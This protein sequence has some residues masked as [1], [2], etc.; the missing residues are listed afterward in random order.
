MDYLYLLIACIFFSLQFIFTKF[1]E[2]RTVGGLSV[3]LYNGIISASVASLFLIVKS[4][5]PAEMN[6]GAFLVALLYSLSGIVCGVSSFM[7]MTYG[8]VSA[9]TTFCLAG[10]MV[11]PYFYGIYLGENP[12]VFKWIG[13]IVLM[14]SLIPTLLKKEETTGRNNRIL[15]IIA[16]SLVFLTN[17]LVSVFS[18]MH[19]I[20]PFAVSEDSFIMTASFIRLALSLLIMVILAVVSTVKGEKSAFKKAFWEIGKNKMRVKLFILL[21]IFA[22]SY[23]VCNTLGNIFSLKCMVTMDASIQFPILSAVVIVLGAVF[24][25]IFFK[26]KITKDMALSLILSVIGIGLFMIP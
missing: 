14:I 22:G 1:F 6:L 12:G 5:L 11:V 2:K 23:A 4:G 10:G 19:Q 17:G 9:V 18:K 7:G 3:S 16:V 20:A 13:I 25:R 24:G 21:V 8:K 15:Y 26:E